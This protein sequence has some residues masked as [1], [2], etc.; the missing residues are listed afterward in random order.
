MHLPPHQM[1]QLCLPFLF[2]LFTSIPF[3]ATSQDIKTERTVLLRLKQQLGNPPSLSHWNTSSSP[4][5]WPEINCTSNS[6]TELHLGDKNITASVPPIICDLTNLTYLDL[7]NNSIPGEFPMLYD[8]S[9]LEILVLSQNYFV[10]PIPDD[11]D[12]L[13]TLVY[14]DI[15]G[16]NFSGD[17]P[18]SIG[19]L[20]VLNTLNI[21]QN[22][23]NGTFPKEIGNLSN[24]AILMMAYNEFVTMRIPP[25]FGQMSKL[26]YLWMT[27]TNLIGEIPES[28]N[29]LSGLEHLDM[30]INNLEGP[31]PRS[32]LSL[33]NLTEVYLY[34][35][36]LSGEI[37]KTI[38][39][40]SLTKVDLSMN[41]LTG[42]IP[43]DFGKLQYLEFLNLAYNQLTAELPT[44]IAQLPAL[45]DFRVFRNMLSG[46]LSPEFGLHSKLEGFEVSENQFSG[47]LPE[48]LCAG[49]VLQG[50]IAY[51]NNL[52][53][54]IPESLGNC[55][56]LRTIQLHNNKFSGEIPPR[57]WTTFN[58]SVFLLTNNS[59]SGKLPSR[60]TWNMSRV[61][62]S[63]NKFS[64]EIPPG[65]ASWSN[66][67]VFQASNNLFSGKIPKEVT[68]LSRLTALLL[69]GND[70]SGE[71]PSEIISWRS[72]TTL[73]V[74]NN[75][76]SGEIPAAIASLPDL[77]YLDLSENQFSGEI[78]S[79]IGNQRLASL[80]L[81]S[82]QLVGKIPKQLNNLAYEGSFMKNSGL[83]ADH[84][85]LKLP[86][87]NFKIHKPD[88]L[89]SKCIAMIVALSILTSTIILLLSF[90]LVRDYRRKKYGQYLA[91]W[92][93]T[94]FQRLGFTKGNIL[95]NLTDNNL[96]G[97]GGSGKVYRV[98][99]N[100]LGES[101]AVKKIWNSKEVDH[102]LEKEF[103]AEVE[104]LS[105][106]RHSNIVKLLCCI[107]S[108]DSKLLVYEYMENRSLDRWLHGNKRSLVS[109]SNSV[110]H[111]VLDWPRRLQ[112]AVG[113]AQGLC[114]MHHECLA[115]IIHRDVKSSNILL[116]SEFNAKIADFGLAKML[117]RHASAHSISAV[118]GSFGY[119]A[120]EYAYT[121][122]V[123]AKVDVYSFG[124]V[125]L[126]LVT[127]KEA[128]S[129]DENMSL[130]ELAWQDF[131]EDKPMVEILDPEVKETSY[132]E[133][134][135]L[136]YKV[137]ILCT[138]ASP[139]NRPSMKE[140]SHILRSCC[141]PNGHAAKKVGSDFDV[142][143]LLGRDNPYL[144]S[145]K[146]GKKGSKE[147]D[148]LI[149]IV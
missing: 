107:S 106:I 76:L 49:G 13:S 118:A 47:Q 116:D 69:D 109:G 73:D 119:L 36:K 81:S 52:T 14:L 59:F 120:P 91:T 84:P 146:H 102:K 62:I 29:N 30:A 51:T 66:L 122:K 130:A 42:S 143:P 86:D 113:A 56:T 124:V 71:L 89:S 9:K 96:I 133:E 115:P 58:L 21:V 126:E 142:S 75:K 17:I 72:L 38:D 127:G 140:V 15:S 22:Q 104:I 139:S 129:A 97:S 135:M 83:C 100:R 12:R 138:D 45:R 125:L 68:N 144:S 101:V 123:N 74:S 95:S 11:I 149:N 27:E 44:S 99:V 92:K 61:E 145:Y 35:N 28:F 94:S 87:C 40:S 110:H 88:K 103:L 43:E 117:T 55:P 54:R 23:F 141:L 41:N 7:Y 65:I 78:P 93:L 32:L 33:K 148:N 90:F 19:R 6:I 8:C 34:H 37:P 67:V 1:S 108:D 10:G 4:C 20:P 77:L 39:A 64:G 111:D 134:M 53:G 50:V 132:L 147:D 114:Y 128:N 136:V 105:N 112:I 46:V 24:L 85:I 31:I 25:E 82:N 18:T 137:G 98:A 70:L 2:L 63:N 48:H 131:S 26:R 16:N 80:N 5:D 60:V 79:E 57:L 121:T 3:K